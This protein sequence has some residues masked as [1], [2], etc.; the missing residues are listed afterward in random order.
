[1]KGEIL[2]VIFYGSFIFVMVSMFM[3]GLI[4]FIE[5]FS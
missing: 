1:M 5:V 3:I 2:K 4:A